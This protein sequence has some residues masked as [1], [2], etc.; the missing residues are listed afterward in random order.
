MFLVFG[1]II[2]EAQTPT[3][4]GIPDANHVLVVYKLPE[5]QADTI[6]IGLANY[7]KNRRGI[8]ANNIVGLYL[9]DTTITIN[10]TTHI[11][12]LAQETD[13][14]RDID[15]DAIWAAT[16]TFHAWRY[17]LDY[18]AAPIK[19]WITSHN[20][21]STI[22]YILLVK[23]V[24]FK[25]QARGD[26]SGLDGTKGNLTVD[27]LL[28]MLNTENYD[29]F[30]TNEVYPNGGISNPYFNDDPNLTMDYRFVPDHFVKTWNGYNV[31]LS[32][33][34]SHLDG[35]SY[36]I[37][38]GMIDR[39]IAPD[40]SGTAA[41]ILDDDPTYIGYG[42]LNSTRDK[43]EELGFNIVPDS[44]D[45]WVTSYNGDVMGYTSWGTHAEDD[46][47]NWEDSAWVVDSLHFSWAKGA[48]FNAP[49]SF[50]GNSLTML[51]WGHWYEDQS[52]C[53]HTQGLATQF[54]QIGGTGTMGHAWEPGLGGVVGDS[55]FFPAYAMG[56]NLVDAI[57]QGKR[58]LAT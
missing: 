38:K 25:I 7:Y 31:K 32:Y 30:I 53:G 42:Y 19:N 27:G 54:T 57:Y 34:V 56:Y 8:P 5:S 41:W 51:Q 14:I 45:S 26:W 44:T 37:V 50:N 52:R 33:L 15:Q 47:C 49:E 28:C 10:D 43:L 24:P 36:D 3:D 6:S 29:S 2:S 58:G 46:N 23:G 55:I 39:S 35:I 18:V 21:T 12:G 48:V 17:Y 20:L 40:M 1:T 9:P 22:R 16:P 11:V 4:A 13:I